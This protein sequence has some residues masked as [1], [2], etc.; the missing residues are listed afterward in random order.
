MLDPDFRPT[1]DGR[2]AVEAFAGVDYD[3]RYANNLARSGYRVALSGTAGQVP[4]SA[5]RWTQGQL[6]T[7]GLVPLTGRLT[8]AGRAKVGLA[9]GDV[10]HRLLNLGGTGAVQGLPYNAA[11]GNQRL[12]TSGEL[13]WL[14]IQ[15]ASVPLPLMWASTMQL[16]GGLDAGAIRRS[17]TLDTSAPPELALGWSF[18]LAFVADILGAD[19]NFGGLWL[20]GPLDGEGTLPSPDELQL[21]LRISQPF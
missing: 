5:Q 3:T 2:L 19:P 17:S 21:Y 12:I 13:R 20:A 18:G 11:V 6:T 9:S 4:E 1:D 8:L 7:Q 10:E 16:S 14:P 15:H